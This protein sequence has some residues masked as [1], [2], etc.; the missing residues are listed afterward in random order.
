ML[1]K[2][3]VLFWENVPNVKNRIGFSYKGK[4]VNLVEFNP[5]NQ[6][7]SVALE[8]VKELAQGVDFEIITKREQLVPNE[9]EIAYFSYS[10]DNQDL[11]YSNLPNNSIVIL[12]MKTESNEP[13]QY[14]FYYKENTVIYTTKDLYDF[15]M[16]SIVHQYLLQNG[17]KIVENL[18]EL[19]PQPPLNSIPSNSSEDELMG[20]DSFG[21][22]D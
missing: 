13:P 19:R 1:C 4:G 21:E 22:K 17:Y 14:N 9:R 12:L 7:F 10:D 11:I 2:N 16:K 15:E 20:R 5:K 18:N 6:S 8:K 3:Q